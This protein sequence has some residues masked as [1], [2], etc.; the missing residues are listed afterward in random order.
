[1]I[2]L[3]T[4]AS[5]RIASRLIP[6]RFASWA[7]SPLSAGR[8]AAVISPAPAVVHHR[9]ADPAHQVLAEPDLRVHHPGA[10]EDRPVAEVREVAGDRRRADV[11]RDAVGLVVQARPDAGDRL[12]VMDRD[13][14][15]V[16]ARLERR[17]ERPDDVEVGLEIVE[18]PLALE[19]LLERG[20]GRPTATRAAGGSTST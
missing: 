18:V 14:D 5:S 12:L 6:A 16:L 9:V 20:G 11:D 19:R 17:L 8:T 1:M 13:R 10:G 4:I 3:P 15:A 2:G 7:R